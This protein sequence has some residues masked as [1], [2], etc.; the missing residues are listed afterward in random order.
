MKRL[1]IMERSAKILDILCF[2]IGR[3]GYDI[4]PIRD[5]FRRDIVFGAAGSRFD[6]PGLDRTYGQHSD[7]PLSTRGGDS[8]TDT[9]FGGGKTVC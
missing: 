9:C 7:L 4:V 2:A 5:G 6:Y 3:E 1:M 8:D